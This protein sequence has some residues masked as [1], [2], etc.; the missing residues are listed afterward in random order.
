MGIGVLADCL[1]ALRQLLSGGFIAAWQVYL[2][3]KVH[4]LTY[5]SYQYS[6]MTN[7]FAVAA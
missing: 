7:R 2:Y 1:D 4:V 3:V 6:N 5:V